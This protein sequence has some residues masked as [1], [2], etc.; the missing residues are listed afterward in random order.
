[1]S[2]RL[3]VF[4]QGRIEQVGTPGR[5]LRASRR[6]RSSPTS[7][8]PR[9]CSA[10]G[11][12]CGPRSCASRTPR[13][14]RKAGEESAPRDDRGRR[15]SRADH[16]LRRAAR[17]RIGA[18]R[19]SAE[20]RAD[21]YGSAGRPGAPG[22]GRL[23]RRVTPSPSTTAT[24]ERGELDEDAHRRR[25]AGDGRPAR[26][27]RR[28]DREARGARSSAATLKVVA[29]EGYTENQW[30]KPFEKQ[31]GCT[32]QHQY[33]GSS[34]EMYNLMKKNAGY[35]LVSASGDASNRLIASGLVQ[36]HRPVAD[37]QLEAAHAAAR[38]GPE[39]VRRRQALRRPVAVGPERADVEHG[40]VQ[41][42]HELVV[43]AL[44]PE[45]QGPDHDPEQPDPDRRRGALPVED[46]ALARH[47]GSLRADLRPSST[48]R[49]PCSRRSA[50]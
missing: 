20:P 1:M 42:R 15:L 10:T 23:G 22:T 6:R 17:G 8:A 46:E 32:V 43:R 33:A 41:G 45:E 37:P 49:S 21:V 14:P 50:R 38:E 48:R 5:G 40:Q 39:P 4:N 44:R 24:G 7:S 9:T 3:A 34:D 30:V 31:T 28:R 2:D 25:R 29:W 19:T 11:S 36:R 16:A 26:D 13:T 47:Q 12:R 27:D 35:D 18:R